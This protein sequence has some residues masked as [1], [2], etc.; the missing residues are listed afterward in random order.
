[1]FSSIADKNVGEKLSPAG[2]EENHSGLQ[3]KQKK[4]A[5]NSNVMKNKRT[6]QTN[7]SPSSAKK[8]KLHASF[9]SNNLLCH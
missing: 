4:S 6:Q 1:M 3:S 2:N 5:Q 7:E 8:K 9:S